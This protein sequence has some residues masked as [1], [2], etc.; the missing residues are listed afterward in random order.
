[1]AFRAQARQMGG[2]QPLIVEVQEPLPAQRSAAFAGQPT[3]RCCAEDWKQVGAAKCE[4]FG[5]AGSVI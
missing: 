5:R 2:G 3:T 1:M 4:I